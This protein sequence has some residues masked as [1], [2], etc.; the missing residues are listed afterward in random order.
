[1]F[2]PYAELKQLASA[3]QAE[4]IPYALC[5]GLA[6]AVHGAAR[7][8]KDI[9]L[10]A[11][12][13]DLERIAELAKGLGFR[14]PALPMTFADGVTL[15]RF[16]KLVDAR[17]LPLDVLLVNDAL[18]PLFDDRLRLPWEGGELQV[19]SRDGLVVL[20]T[21]AG[22]PQDLVDIQRLMELERDGRP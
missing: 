10:L 3:L 16:T 17:P 13:E 8:T 4:G 6:L 12:P 11:L 21:S 9:D 18:R 19:V 1:M 14:F 15:R 7:A 22:R 2:D 20:K 5:G